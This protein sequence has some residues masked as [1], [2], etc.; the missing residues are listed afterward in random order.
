MFQDVVATQ[1]NSTSTEN[2]S[3]EASTQVQSNLTGEAS[4]QTCD[5]SAQEGSRYVKILVK[6]VGVIACDYSVMLIFSMTFVFPVSGT[7]GG[8]LTKKMPTLHLLVP[9]H[10]W[11]RFKKPAGFEQLTVQTEF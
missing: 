11:T 9:R 4:T 2:L 1:D 6:S 5:A 3:C 8:E 7:H 10:S